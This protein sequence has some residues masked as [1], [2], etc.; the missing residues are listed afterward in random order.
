[1]PEPLRSRLR[2]LL[3]LRYQLLSYL[4]TVCYESSLGL[5]PILRPVELSPG[6]KWAEHCMMFGPSVLI[7]S[8]QDINTKL[9]LPPGNWYHVE[10]HELATG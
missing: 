4:Y 6:G 1:M 5:G 8:V 2:S 3:H 10:T 7:Y 9:D